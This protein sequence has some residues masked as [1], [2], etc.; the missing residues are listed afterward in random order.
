MPAVAFAAIWAEGRALTPDDAIEFA[1]APRRAVAERTTRTE[2][3]EAGKTTGPLAPRERE[4]AT[5]VARGLTN[6]E[7]ASL[8]V[9]TER[10][11]ETHVQHILNKLGF[12]SRAQIAAWAVENG[13]HATFPR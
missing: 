5:L 8:L 3:S 6:H 13:L 7:I 2:M 11:A 1:L 9:I 4:V 12:K 10:T